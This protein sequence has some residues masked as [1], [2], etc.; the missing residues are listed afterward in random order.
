MTSLFPPKVQFTYQP[1]LKVKQ[2]SPT[3]LNIQHTNIKRVNKQEPAMNSK[4]VRN[5]NESL[6]LLKIH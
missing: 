6:F 3:T 5:E 1:I 2:T 4:S